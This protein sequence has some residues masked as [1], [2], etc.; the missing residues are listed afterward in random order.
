M[1]T[2]DAGARQP[3]QGGSDV[4]RA[5]ARLRAAGQ[6]LTPQRLV[7]LEAFAPGEHLTAEEVYARIAPLLPVVT[8]STVYRTLELFRD[9]GLVSETDL[10]GEA[11]R[12][13]LLGEERHHHLICQRCGAALVLDDDVVRPL[14][15]AVRERFGFAAR[16]DHLALFGECA[17]CR[18]A[19]DA[20]E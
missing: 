2:D 16:I 4:L 8:H 18:Q 14:R 15:D 1:A 10:G 3:E 19:G 7:I 20:A 17:A 12:F 13:E 11:R 5:A 6:R 9:L